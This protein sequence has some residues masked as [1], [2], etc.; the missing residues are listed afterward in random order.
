[1]A[2]PPAAA[3]APVAPVEEEVPVDMAAPVDAPV[4]DVPEEEATVVATILKNAD[5]SYTL[6]SGAGDMEMDPA[7]AGGEAAAMP[8]GQSF[9]ADEGG[10]G[11][12]MT[13]ILDLV[14][15]EATG[16]AA[17]Q[18]AFAEGFGGEE[19]EVPVAPV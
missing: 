2:L 8:A 19:A 5:G 12:L 10:I 18:A 14:D 13:A 15:P 1:M 3:A 16:G 17:S 11:Q 9:P 7:M 4:E 6:E